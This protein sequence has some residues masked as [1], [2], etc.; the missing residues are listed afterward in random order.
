MLIMHRK[1]G[2]V[3]RTLLESFSA[4]KRINAVGDFHVI[5]YATQD[6]LFPDPLGVL[7]N[8]VDCIKKRG[9]LVS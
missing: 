9:D 6:W 1:W 3:P 5:K 8:E 4:G 7:E 2:I